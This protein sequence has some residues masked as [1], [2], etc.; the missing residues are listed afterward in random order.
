MPAKLEGMAFTAPD[1]FTTRPTLRGSF[2]MVATTHWLASQSAM[3]VLER[4]GNAFDAAVAA[5]FVLHI[6]EPHLN[7]PGGDLVGLIA[8][9]GQPPRVLAGLGAAPRGASIEHYRALGLD[10]VPGA[11]FLAATAP[12]AFDAWLLLLRD[13]GT[14]ELQE[15]VE[16]ALHYAESGYPVLPAVA[17]TIHAVDQLFRT[18]WPT[19]AAVWCGVEAHDLATRPEWATT[20]RRL[21]VAGVGNTREQRI[22]AV[23]SEW[24]LGFVAEQA[25]E[26]VRTP[27]RDSSGAEHTGILTRDDFADYT[28]TW[29]QPVDL[30]FR[31]SRVVK[32]GA[33]TQGPA[34]L[35]SLA[36]LDGFEDDRLDPSTELGAHTILEVLKLALA[37]RDAWYGDD[38]STPLDDLLSPEYSSV[39]RAL[40]TDVA[41]G[42]QRP[43]SP[44]GREPHLPGDRVGVATGDGLAGTGEPTVAKNGVTRGDTCHLDIVDRFGN[45]ASITPSGGWLQ[46]SPHIPGLGFCL[47]SRLQMTW[48]EEGLPS[49]L[50]PGRRPRTTLSPTLVFGPD[51]SILSTGTP[52]GDQQDQWQLTFLLRHLVGGYD[53]QQ[54]IDAPNLHTTSAIESFWPRERVPNGAVIEDRIGREVL[55]GLRARGHDVSVAG[56]WTLGR[57]SAASSSADG[58][59]AAANPR[60]MQGYAV[61]R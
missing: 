36:I 18:S 33:W 54:A 22:D 12:G 5:G 44:G 45:V 8:P 53:L 39:R 60:G 47:G 42:A 55:E 43:G 2:G 17:R 19:S 13:H 15:V 1:E 25:S 41:S 59:R 24:S 51:G 21:L 10:L 37:D 49:S 56:S 29:E 6:V 11:G 9:A 38:G 27:L 31:G 30:Q 32:A 40:V 14:W 61:G 58:L 52:G 26:F 7:G 34:L 4:G 20:L 28:A 50:H 48:L 3:A 16:F 23:R 57:L 35:Q 46:S